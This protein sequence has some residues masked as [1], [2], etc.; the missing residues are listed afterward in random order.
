MIFNLS[1][2]LVAFALTPARLVLAT[3]NADNHVARL[4]L[5][6]PSPHHEVTLN[7]RHM[8]KSRLSF[9]SPAKRARHRKRRTCPVP[10]SASPD[11]D[12]PATASTPEPSPS[13]TSEDPSPTPV[14][15][16]ESPAASP[17]DP[18]SSQ[19][20]DQD[21]TSSQE[22]DPAPQDQSSSGTSDSDPNI[23]AYLS[24]C[25][26]YSFP[27]PHPPILT[28]GNGKICIITNEPTTVLRP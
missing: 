3:P 23:Q 24:T 5:R 2:L 16:P 26:Q 9:E 6:G 14:A 11:P 18:T 20:Q 4:E 25:F 19:G 8:K 13:P 27:A 17:P 22:Q 7:S 28:S 15:P 10:T 12:S 1:S 21:P